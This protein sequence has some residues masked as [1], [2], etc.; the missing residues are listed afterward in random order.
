MNK[1]LIFLSLIL[2]AIFSL[3]IYNTQQS[4]QNA[5]IIKTNPNSTIYGFDEGNNNST[6][7]PEVTNFSEKISQKIQYYN[8]KIE[9]FSVWTIVLNLLVTIITGISALLT[10]IS[11]IKNNSVTKSTAIIIAVITFVSTLLS[12]G[13]GVVTSFKDKAENNRNQITK[14]REE[15]QSLK[16]EEMID[17]INTNLKNKLNEIQ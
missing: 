9:N 5:S 6:T 14:I 7:P 13:I 4:I 1:Y 3:S 11:S 2:L 16:P 12:S 8:A 17:Q 15:L 10:T